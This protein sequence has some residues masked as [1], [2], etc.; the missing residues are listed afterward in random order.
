MSA[1]VIDIETAGEPWENIDEQT[2]K[3]L[4]KR[5]EYQLPNSETSAEEYAEE[6]LGI[7][8]LTGEIVALG[9]ID[10]STSKGAVYYQTPGKKVPDGEFRGL[11]LHSCTEKEMLE[12]FWE[13]S[14]R[15]THFVTYSGRSFDIPYLMIRSA[16]HG[17]K[18]KKD[19]MRGRYIYQ[20]SPSAIHVDLY[21]QL[22][23]YGAMRLGGLHT[24]CRAFGIES[25]KSDEIDGSKV[26][27]YFR[28]G[29]YKEIAEYNAGD[30]FAT[31]DLY[32][33]WKE[34]LVF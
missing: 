14:D 12:R 32:N 28:S 9:L 21:D 33:K 8:P 29:K 16:I 7:S 31:K 23:F 1:L 4:I 25:P 17:I 18:P 13:L 2:K 11:K 6:M 26:S 34:L 27:E 5:A 3:I 22:T 19:L 30:L 15:Y 24:V 20:Q 10:T